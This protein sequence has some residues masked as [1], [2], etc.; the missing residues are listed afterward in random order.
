VGVC[1]P[2]VGNWAKRLSAK[3]HWA[4]SRG[5]M[6]VKAS[7]CRRLGAG[8]VSRPTCLCPPN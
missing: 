8:Q 7:N 2:G 6:Q 3:P 4:G 1:V 5:A